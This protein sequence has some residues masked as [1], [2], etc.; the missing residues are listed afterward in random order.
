[1]KHYKKFLSAVLAVGIL[2][3]CADEFDRNFNA[4]KPESIA[5]YEY[6]S[7]YDALKSYVDHNASP[8]FKLGAGVEVGDFLKRET[9]YAA[10]YTNFDEVVAGNAMKYS[11]CV[12]DNG[13]MDFAQ[14]TKFVEVSRE[15]G[16]DIYG[17]TLC[18]HAQQNTKYLNGLIADKVIEIDPEDGDNILYINTPSAQAAIWDWQ[19]YRMLSAP[20]IEGVEYT[21]T[22]RVKASAEK[23]EIGFWPTQDTNPPL[24]MGFSAGEEWSNITMNF[25]ANQAINKLQF[26]FGLFAGDLYFDDLCLTA[27]G[28]EENL[29]ENSSFDEKDLS[30]W[31]KPGW[32][33]FTYSIETV[34]AGP[35][36][37]WTDLVTNG[38]AEGDDV[39]CFYATEQEVGGPNPATIGALGTGADGIGRA[40]VVQSSNNPPEPHSTQFFVKVPRYLMAGDKYRFTMKY[41]ALKDA[42]CSS[43]SHN[44]PGGYIHWEMLSGNPKFTTEWQE[45]TWTGAISE[46]QA[47]GSGGT[48]PNGM[49]TIAFNLA[50]LGEANT[51]YFDDIK[52]EIEESGAGIPLTPEEKK[53]VLTDA[54]EVWIA[55]MMEACDGYVKAWDVV[56]EPM[57][58]GSPYELKSDPNKEDKENFYWQ[59]YLGKEYARD[60]VRLARQYGGEDL[61]LFINDYNLEA[62]YNNNAKCEGLIKMVEYWESDGVTRIDGIGTQMHVAYNMDPEKQKKQEE[63]VVKMYELLAAT[64]KLVKV[65][66]LDMGILDENGEK[67]KTEN[68]SFEQHKRMADFY[69][70]I[71]EKYFEI[72]PAAQQ[73]GITQWAQTDSPAESGWRKG[74]PIGLWDLNY[75]R[76]PAYGGFANGL[77]GRDILED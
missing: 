49:N 66:E 69:Q 60:A 18:W 53:E 3:S 22:M 38:D 20:L 28:S 42:S 62:T 41:K 55:G 15:A 44:N 24:Y 40:F 17:H 34:A 58:D 26:C 31:G 29:I 8:N 77:A 25:K 21:F 56:N 46:T 45:H 61:K 76:K 47:Y 1:M 64:G 39:S 10:S 19:I 51:Y 6:L 33:A 65:S 35:S 50:E 70:F 63:C 14:V 32:H 23:V 75:S 30:C 27:A 5:Q 43:Q 7:V 4:E 2:A 72:I 12:A 13:S 73:Y 16:L 67:I 9:V 52:F 37:W 68:T 74:E 11:S 59:D 54:L 71:V 36:T 57:S 48:N